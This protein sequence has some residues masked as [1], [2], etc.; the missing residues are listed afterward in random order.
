L[1]R[2]SVGTVTRDTEHLE[3]VDDSETN[4]KCEEKKEKKT[5]SCPQEEKKIFQQ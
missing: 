5:A 4:K 2:F 1:Y 3:G